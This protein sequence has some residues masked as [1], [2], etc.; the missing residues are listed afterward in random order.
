MR[1]AALTRAKVRTRNRPRGRKTGGYD[2]TVG[3]GWI[4]RGTACISMNT[5]SQ[6]TL[7]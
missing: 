2:G 1:L 3:G 6:E 5:D 4:N 7:T